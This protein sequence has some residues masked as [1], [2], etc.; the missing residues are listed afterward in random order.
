MSEGGGTLSTGK[1]IALFL[2]VLLGGAVLVIVVF[3][4]VLANA[5]DTGDGAPCPL[6]G[7]W[8]TAV[9]EDAGQLVATFD[10]TD[11]GEWSLAFSNEYGEVEAFGRFAFSHDRV[12][13]IHDSGRTE[14]F[15]EVE[16]ENDRLN[17]WGDGLPAFRRVFIE[18]DGAYVIPP[19]RERPEPPYDDI[20]ARFATRFNTAL[21]GVV[22]YNLL[23]QMQGT[24]PLEGFSFD[25][26]NALQMVERLERAEGSSLPQYIY[27]W[28]NE[29][30][31]AV[32]QIL[33]GLGEEGD[34]NDVELVRIGGRFY[35]PDGV[36]AMVH[37]KK[38]AIATID[39]MNYE[40]LT[41]METL[42]SIPVNSNP[43]NINGISFTRRVYPGGDFV[44]IAMRDPK[45]MLD[46][47]G[48]ESPPV[49]YGDGFS[50]GLNQLL[51]LLSTMLSELRSVYFMDIVGVRYVAEREAVVL[52]VTFHW[53]MPSGQIKTTTDYFYSDGDTWLGTTDEY[54]DFVVRAWNTSQTHREPIYEVSEFNRVHGR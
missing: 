50:R 3:Y 4:F 13:L 46:A 15:D 26:I 31:N 51:P 36:Y 8:Q 29:D 6:V 53:V 52:A 47:M 10:F 24:P 12:V 1:A 28:I 22:T 23:A 17:I 18:V 40:P 5:L 33:E 39:P 49:T 45:T 20:Q 41:L 43:V 44:F 54:A 48:V 30:V 34:A 37:M 35:Q 25:A 11:T 42:V 14:V 16:I 21:D 32:I 7:R 19:A 9:M 38:G 27:S 2:L